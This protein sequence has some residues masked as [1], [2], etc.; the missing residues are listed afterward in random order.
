MGWHPVPGLELSLIGRNLL[1]ESHRE[2]TEFSGNFLGQG[3]V[4]T[5]VERSFLVQAKWRF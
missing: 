3:L 1:D 4:S 2:F 5:Q